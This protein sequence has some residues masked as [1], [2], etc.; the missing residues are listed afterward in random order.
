MRAKHDISQESEEKDVILQRLQPFFLRVELLKSSLAQKH[1]EL[2]VLKL[3]LNDLFEES[4]NYLDRLSPSVLPSKERKTRFVNKS[5]SS[6][7]PA[8][9]LTDRMQGS[10]LAV[11]KRK[12]HLPSLDPKLW[13]TVF[14]FLTDRELLMLRPVDKNFNQIALTYFSQSYEESLK[15]L[16]GRFE[17]ANGVLERALPHLPSDFSPEK[18]AERTLP[19]V[20]KN[21]GSPPIAAIRENLLFPDMDMLFSA[22]ENKEF[23]ESLRRYNIEDWDIIETLKL[24]DKDFSL[25]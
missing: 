24:I 23:F 17:R 1:A 10:L 21:Y 19:N 14:R 25:N 6:I 7:V 5:K 22:R 8:Q 9:I 16:R 3:A 4:N 15:T 18:I 20:L 11:T 13:L 2:T 12:K